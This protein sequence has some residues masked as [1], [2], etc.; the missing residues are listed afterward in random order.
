MTR[1]PLTV[2]RTALE[3][4][5]EVLPP[6][7]SKFSKKAFTQPQL[8]AI[9]ILQQFLKTDYRTMVQYLREWS[10]LRQVLGLRTVPHYS[11][12]AYAARRLLKKG[13]LSTCWLPSLAERGRLA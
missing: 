3:V 7:S 2:A 12:L 10:D 11:T 9:L 1:S 4:A 6:Y 13:L 8:L 5:T